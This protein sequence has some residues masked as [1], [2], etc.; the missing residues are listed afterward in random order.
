[1]KLAELEPLQVFE[2][3]GVQYE[4][5]EVY[6]GGRIA[7][8][9]ELDAEGNYLPNGKNVDGSKAYVRRLISDIRFNRQHDIT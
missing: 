3:D 2:L 6:P 7:V 1:M 4:C 8:C 9:Y 5:V